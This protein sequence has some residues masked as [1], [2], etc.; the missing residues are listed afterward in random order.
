MH[1]VPVRLAI[2]MF[3]NRDT[4]LGDEIV[5]HRI[6]SQRE[7]SHA[8]AS[9]ELAN[10][11]RGEVLYLEVFLDDGVGEERDVRPLISALAWSRNEKA[12]LAGPSSALNGLSSDGR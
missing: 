6:V 4:C 8:S 10:G 7:A 11:V 1:A 12:P 3:C 2:A 5:G 9:S